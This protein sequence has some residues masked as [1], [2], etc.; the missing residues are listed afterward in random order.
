M[1]LIAEATR[2]ITINTS[3]LH[4]QVQVFETDQ[5]VHET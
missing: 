1:T 3:K 5:V 4:V 2:I